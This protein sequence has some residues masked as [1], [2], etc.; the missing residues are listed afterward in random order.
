MKR[1]KEGDFVKIDFSVVPVIAIVKYTNE[2]I[3]KLTEVPN[4]K[5]SKGGSYIIDQN[6]TML[7]LI[8]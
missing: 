8:K 6:N 7:S 3:I 1:F 5:K 2:H 4:N